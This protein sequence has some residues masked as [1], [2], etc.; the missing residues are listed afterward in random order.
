[1]RKFVCGIVLF[2]SAAA[3]A[4][5]QV[6]LVYQP[7]SKPGHETKST[8]EMKLEQLLTIAGMPIETKVEN[9]VVQSYKVGDPLPDGGV[10][11]VQKTETL[12]LNLSLPGGL[13]FNFDSG[14]PST[15]TAIPQ[16]KAVAE[17]L[18]KMSKAELN[19]VYGADGKIKEI[20]WKDDA[21]ANVDPMYKS[22]VDPETLKK[23]MQQELDRLPGK[24]VNKGDSWTRTEEVNLGGSQKMT[25]ES[26]YTYT[27]PG[28]VDGKAVEQIAVKAKSVK[29]TMDAPTAD[30]VLFKNAEVSVKDSSGTLSYDPALKMITRSESAMHLT[31][32]LTLEVAGMELA[33]DLDLK[34]NVKS[35]VK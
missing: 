5:A 33:T 17:F 14:N 30:G 2:L 3:S 29:L 23:T 22:E 4:S 27:G 34:M 16:L 11:V 20:K 28:T 35:D 26:E 15:D 24:V 1:M 31:G 25:V 32:K 21:F 18:A 8:T 10:P 19:V 12:Q 9:F 6:N 7:D 13:S